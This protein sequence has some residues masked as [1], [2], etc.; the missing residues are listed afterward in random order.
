VNRLIATCLNVSLGRWE[1]FW[2][3][4]QPCAV[5]LVSDEDILRK[6]VYSQANP[7]S[8]YLVSHGHKWPGVRTTPKDLLS[9][10]IE[11]ERPKGYFR[12]DGKMPKKA[13]LKLVRPPAY[14][15]L[16]DEAFVELFDKELEER[17]EE[18]REQAKAKKIRFLG[19]RRILRQRPTDAPRSKEP[20]RKLKPRVAAANKWRRIEALQR[21][22]AFQAAYREAWL[23][24]KQG[25][26]DVVFP[27]GTY[28]LARYAAV[29]CAPS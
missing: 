4:E 12:E 27:A 24:W 16:S 11:V 9:E 1:N 10:G 13:T 19:V 7:V 21:L 23:R 6:M 18:I 29:V 26:V 3:A 28:A 15:H 20:R 25:F 14:E 2:A 17:E 8:S 22:K 5:K